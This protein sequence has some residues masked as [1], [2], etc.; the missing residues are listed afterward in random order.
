M[1]PG[2]SLSKSPIS[3]SPSP[4]KKMFPDAECPVPKKKQAVKESAEC[5]DHH[6]RNEKRASKETIKKPSREVI[7]ET[8]VQMK[9]SREC[10]YRENWGGSPVER[11]GSRKLDS[12]SFQLK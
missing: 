11:R 12:S 1:S 10:E 9:P 3:Q 6:L 8:P 5:P 2:R 4:S 7:S